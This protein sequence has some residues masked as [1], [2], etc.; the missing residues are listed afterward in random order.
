MTGKST[1]SYTPY[2]PFLYNRDDIYV[3]RIA[4]DETSFHIE[5]M[6]TNK[7]KGTKVFLR[8]E[9]Q[10]EFEL[11]AFVFKPECTIPDL[12][13]NTD[14]EFYLENGD[15]KS[16]VRLVRTGKNVGTVVNYLHPRD[17]YYAFSGRYLCSPSFIR[18]PDGYLLS[19]MDLFAGGAPQ[20]L[21][22]IFRSDDEGKTWHYVC[23]LFPCFWGRLFVHKGMVYMLSCSTE[24]GDLLIGKSKDGMTWEAPTVLLRGSCKCGVAGVH[25]NPQPVV[26]YNGRLYETLEWGSWG[27]GYH[28]AMVMSA[29]VDADLTK[30]ESWHF[31]PPVKYDKNWKGVAAG[32]SSGNIEGCLVTF[33]DGKLY[34]VMRYDM[35]R[36]T[37][38]W[39]MALAYLVHTEDPDAPLTFDRP[40]AFPGAHTKF[41][42]KKDEVSGRY[43]AVCTRNLNDEHAAKFPRNVL[44]LMVSDDAEHW[45]LCTDIIDRHEDDTK[46]TGFQYPDFMFNGDDIYVLC[47]TAINEPHNFHDANYQT[48][49]VIRDFRQYK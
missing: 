1:W 2:V 4:P 13:E 24:Y 14:Y 37:P 28:A 39:G 8:R 26:E 31:T 48:F 44:S 16:N 9:G 5:W 47:R 42:M 23:D 32:E 18:H 25:K 34:N 19:S 21:S 43:Y 41:M 30:P 36:C 29:D 20:N 7:D 27:E 33:P 3:C 12:E 35:S 40:I 38:N 49:H 10:G 45:R 11:K 6:G 15:K 46:F 17:S 22:L